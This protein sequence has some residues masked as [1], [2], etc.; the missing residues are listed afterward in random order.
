M[1]RMTGILLLNW[2]MLLAA[3]QKQIVDDAEWN[4]QQLK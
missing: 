1:Q 4:K 3:V 2:Q